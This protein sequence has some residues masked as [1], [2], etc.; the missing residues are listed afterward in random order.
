M[1]PGT[2]EYAINELVD[3]HIDLSP[4]DERYRNDETGAGRSLRSLLAHAAGAPAIDPAI[5][6]KIVLFAY[7]RG[8]VSSRG[9]A[10][11]CE[12]NIVFMALAADTRPHFTTIADFIS[13]M[14]REI[15]GVFRDVLTVCYSE[16]LIGRR[17]F[18][19]DGCKIS[20]NCAK[21][22]SGTRAEL[23]KKT[24]RGSSHRIVRKRNTRS[25]RLSARRRRSPSG[26]PPTMS[27]LAG[28]G[29]GEEQHH[30][31]RQR[32]AGQRARGDAG[33]YRDRHRR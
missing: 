16:G 22:W 11:E 2:F 12:Q 21:E 1:H 9:I 4:F 33:L 3:H 5:L 10:R 8:I 25:R 18:A 13:T 30:R 24:A 15:V 19:I 26:W 31:Q 28:R 32:Q 27:G 6:L 14:E 29:K 7:S 20:A 17:M 23:M